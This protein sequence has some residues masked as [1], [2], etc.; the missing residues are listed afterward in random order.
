MTMM[1]PGASRQTA[2]LRDDYQ[3]LEQKLARKMAGGPR[4]LRPVKP[5]RM[6]KGRL[7]TTFGG[8]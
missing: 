2:P 6:A 8:M 4:P 3:Q 7:M 5:T 1:G